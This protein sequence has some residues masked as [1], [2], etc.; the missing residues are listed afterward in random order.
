MFLAQEKSQKVAVI[1][2]M[3]SAV[4]PISGLH[5]FY[6]RQPWWGLAYLLLSITLTPP[7]TEMGVLSYFGLAQVASLLEGIWYFMQSEENFQRRFNYGTPSSFSSQ[8][9]QNFHPH[10][11]GETANAIQRLDQLR[12]EGLLSE[13]EF[14]QQRRQ[15]L[16]RMKQ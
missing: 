12:E 14:E 5:K 2:A 7:L 16:E 9:Q 15:L 11:V 8:S 1:L 13:Y 4:T 3:V 6:L 10:L